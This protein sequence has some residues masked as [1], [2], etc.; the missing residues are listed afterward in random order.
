MSFSSRRA[1]S[2]LL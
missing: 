2:C 1:S